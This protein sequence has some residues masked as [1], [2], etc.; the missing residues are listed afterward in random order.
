[1]MA[2]GFVG[3]GGGYIGSQ[4]G[5]RTMLQAFMGN[6]Q[7]AVDR[8]KRERGRFILSRGISGL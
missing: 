5:I 7:M 8:Y 3:W 2:L 6:Y 1:M 4:G